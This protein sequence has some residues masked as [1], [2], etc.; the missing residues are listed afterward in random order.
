MQQITAPVI[1]SRPLVADVLQLVLGAPMLA[2]TAQPGQFVTVRA[3]GSGSYDPLLPIALPLAAL[4]RTAGTVTLLVAAQDPAQRWLAERPVGERLELLGPLGHGWTIA[5]AARNLLLIGTLATAASLL[6]LLDLGLQRGLAVTLII[7]APIGPGL[8]AHLVPSAVE[9]HL[10]RGPDP[11]QAA[12]EL[13]DPAMLSWADAI[14]TTL[15]PAH[16]PALSHQIQRVRVR[17]DRG[18]AATALS[19]PLACGVGVCGA[20]SVQ[21]GR[22]TRLICTDGPI[23]DLRDS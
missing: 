18:L 4:D 2:Q 9:Y 16:W 22:K 7:G 11:A 3:T 8:P 12:L 10:G 20:C 5:S 19:P 13:V 15:P 21:I 6:A 1:Q 23:F 17:W 14:Y